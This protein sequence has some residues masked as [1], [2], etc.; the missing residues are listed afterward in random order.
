MEI[1]LML[2]AIKIKNDWKI[3]IKD[4]IIGMLPEGA[5]LNLCLTCGA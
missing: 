2:E 3:V 4:N 5:N 1:T